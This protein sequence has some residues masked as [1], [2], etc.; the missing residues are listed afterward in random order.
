MPR[1]ARGPRLELREALKQLCPPPSRTTRSLLKQREPR[2][3][4]S[5]SRGRRSPG[6]DCAMAGNFAGQVIVTG[7]L[8]PFCDAARELQR[9]GHHGE[10]ELVD[11]NGRVRMSGEIATHAKWT[12]RETERRGPELIPYRPRPVSRQRRKTADCLFRVG[13]HPTTESAACGEVRA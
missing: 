12:V 6:P 5:S 4:M 9:R 8:T 2:K 3:L 10:L 13:R 11:G 7:S 1:K